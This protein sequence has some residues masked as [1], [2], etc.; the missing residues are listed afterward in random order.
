[1]KKK[2]ITQIRAKKI[3]ELRKLVLDKKLEVAHPDVKNAR[4]IKR[5]IAQILTIIREKELLKKK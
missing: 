4:N 1:M 5:E 2:D 3:P